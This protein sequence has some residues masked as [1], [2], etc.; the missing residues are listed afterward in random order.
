MD[1]ELIAI[2]SIVVLAVVLMFLGFR[3]AILFDRQCSAACAEQSRIMDQ[4]RS[5]TIN[6]VC[7]CG[8]KQEIIILDGE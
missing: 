7:I 4:H 8:S 1:K 6:H 3:E 2:W 5:S